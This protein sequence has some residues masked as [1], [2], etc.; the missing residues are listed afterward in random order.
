MGAMVVPK[1]LNA[2]DKFNLLDAPSSLPKSATK[3]FA[4]TCKIVIP[5]AKVK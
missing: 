2:C 3:G 4:A 5:P 1:E